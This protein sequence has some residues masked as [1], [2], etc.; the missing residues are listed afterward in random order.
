MYNT[1]KEMTKEIAS[2]LS[3]KRQTKRNMKYVNNF[4][5]MVRM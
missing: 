3:I 2:E 5:V 1:K 4:R